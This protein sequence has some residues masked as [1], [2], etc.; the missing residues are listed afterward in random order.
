MHKKFNEF[1]IQIQKVIIYKNWPFCNLIFLTKNIINSFW[2]I[3]NLK[4][5]I[6]S[7]QHKKSKVLY[8]LCKKF[9]FNIEV[10]IYQ[11]ILFKEVKQSKFCESSLLKNWH[12]LGSLSKYS[13]V[14]VFLRFVKML[15]G[16]PELN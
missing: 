8:I 16:F 3:L 11:F 4:Q 2:E 12:I 15:P 9:V 7:K 14:Y 5:E 1:K 10:Y 13:N 6:K